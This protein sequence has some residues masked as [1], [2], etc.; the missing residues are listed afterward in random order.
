MCFARLQIPRAMPEGDF[1]LILISEVAY[2][3]QR[4]ELEQ[5]ATL[6]SERQHAGDTLVLVHLTETVPDYPLTGDQAHDAWLA[7]PE[8]RVRR[9]ERRERYRL[10]VLERV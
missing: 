1:A 8:W 5:A 10:D 6:L 7:R 3:W 2:Y 9:S 4:D